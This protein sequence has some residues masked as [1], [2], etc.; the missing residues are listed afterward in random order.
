MI[1]QIRLLRNIQK[2]DV[3][4]YKYKNELS[5]LNKKL[6]TTLEELTTKE[7]SISKKLE[8]IR[9]LEARKNKIEEEI[10]VEK[11]N[12][13]KWEAR[14]NESRNSREGIALM[15]EIEV[16]KKAIDEME[17]E[18]LK[19]LEEMDSFKKLISDEEKELNNLRDR[20]KNEED[21]LNNKAKG[22]NEKI[23]Q[24]TKERAKEL[25]G[26]KP[27]ILS[28]YDKIKERRNGLA[29]VPIVNGTCSGCHM[30]I[31]P[32]LFTK[33]YA[34]VSIETCPSCQRFIFI[35]DILNEHREE[36]N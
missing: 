15:H 29:I 30:G 12:L 31:P 7:H 33:V 10:K 8:K 11:T 17:E 6:E 2:I 1:N 35:E 21:E 13:K 16:L 34:G 24:L 36:S 26:I 14:L 19:I 22:I 28:E 3:E 25:N 23:E 27:E 32:Q 4:I 18:V 5:N 20:Y 9:E